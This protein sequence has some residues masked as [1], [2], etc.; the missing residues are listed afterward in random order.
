MRKSACARELVV[1]HGLYEAVVISATVHAGVAHAELDLFGSV[2][3]ICF[4][5]L[6]ACIIVEAAPLLRHTRFV[7][8]LITA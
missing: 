7:V 8:H 3:F 2:S 5:F 1:F 6:H 4:A